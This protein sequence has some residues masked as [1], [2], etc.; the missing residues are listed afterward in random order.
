MFIVLFYIIYN[1]LTK[2]TVWVFGSY[3]NVN[4]DQTS[5]GNYCQP[6]LF[7]FAFGTL[8]AQC[9]LFGLLVCFS[10]CILCCCWGK[11]SRNKH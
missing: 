6:T 7:K 2:G 1:F 8:I 4:Y 3:P 10:P 9:I 11:L 5:S